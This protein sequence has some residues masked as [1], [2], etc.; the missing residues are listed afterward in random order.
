MA[1][2]AM[3]ALHTAASISYGETMSLKEA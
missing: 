2:G 3:A 1:A